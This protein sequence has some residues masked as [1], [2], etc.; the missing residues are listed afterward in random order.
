MRRY[1]ILVKKVHGYEH[2]LSLQQSDIMK[3]FI[4]NKQYIDTTKPIDISIPLRAGQSNV[5]AWYCD[6][7]SIVPVRTED[8]TGSVAE[9][10]SVNFRNV[11][12]NPHGNGTHT[13]CVGHITKEV[14]SIND[15][16]KEFWFSAYLITIEPQKIFNKKYN[17]EDKVITLEGLKKALEN[18]DHESSLI[19]RT[20]PNDTEK[21]NHHYSNENP[22]YIAADAMEWIVQNTQVEHLLIDLPSVDR[23]LDD[24]ELA[25]H[26]LFWNVP[27]KPN[28][29]KTITELIFVP[30]NIKDGHY[31]LNLQITSLENDASPSKPVLYDILTLS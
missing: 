17:T 18:Y 14:F 24:G 27:D 6:P 8:F 9:G 11:V 12:L 15:T 20:L 5:N 1:P 31:F 4:D 26:H 28:H 3:F 2:L 13:E 7:V 19:I 22:P 29:H 30:A 16:L 10:G 25:A 21:L 23:E